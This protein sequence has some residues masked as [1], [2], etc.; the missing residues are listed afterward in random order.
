VA[1]V[2]INRGEELATRDGDFEV[3]GE[4]ARVLGLLLKVATT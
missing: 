4:A 2:A 1:A 3:I